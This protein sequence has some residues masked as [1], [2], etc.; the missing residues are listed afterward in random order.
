MSPSAAHAWKQWAEWHIDSGA[1][2][3]V[4]EEPTMR[5]LTA[6]EA[7]A[8][9]VADERPID[10]RQCTLADLEVGATICTEF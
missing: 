3:E 9:R 8:I 2:D 4:D 10:T 1:T 7:A 5:E 6:E